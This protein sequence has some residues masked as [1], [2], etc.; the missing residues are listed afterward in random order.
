MWIKDLKRV[1]KKGKIRNPFTAPLVLLMIKNANQVLNE[2]NQNKS[3]T[4]STNNYMKQTISFLR[5]H[6]QSITFR[7]II[8]MFWQLLCVDNLHVFIFK[9]NG[10]V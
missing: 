9:R 10:L 4:Y 8:I 5:R 2:I 7:D 3:K 1:H 6:Y